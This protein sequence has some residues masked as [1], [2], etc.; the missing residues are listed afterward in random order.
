MTTCYY[1]VEETHYSTG[2]DEVNDRSSGSA[3]RP[4]LTTHE[5]LRATPCGVWVMDNRGEERFINRSWTK[6]YAHATVEEAKAAFRA[7]K[8]RQISIYRARAKA[9]EDAL[10]YLDKHGF[11]NDM[12]KWASR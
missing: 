11:Y 6:Q 7:R 9:L 10:D 8:K 1:R 5:V 4:N 12:S 3:T 2:Y